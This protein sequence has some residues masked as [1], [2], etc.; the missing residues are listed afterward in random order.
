M[1][2]DIDWQRV[3]AGAALAFAAMVCGLA[4]GIDPL[5]AIYVSVAIAFLVVTLTD[6][7]MGLS[8]FIFAGFVSMYAYGRYDVAARSV[9]VLAWLMYVLTR[10]RK[11]LDFQMVHPWAAAALVLFVAWAY[12]SASWSEDVGKAVLSATEYALSGLLMLITYTAV[13]QR[14]DLG[15]ILTAFLFGAVTAIIY[16]LINPQVDSEGRLAN[17]VLGPNVLGEALVCGLAIGVALIVMYR[18]PAMRL[19]TISATLFVGLGV[20]LTTSR[21]ALLALL[22]SLVTAIVLAGRWRVVALCATLVLTG[23]AYIYFKQFAPESQRQRIEQPLSSQQRSSDGRNTIWTLAVRAFEAH[24]VT[25]VGAGNFRVVQR[26]FLLQPGVDRSATQTSEVVDDP[27]GK[28]AHNSFLS[29]ASE[30]GAVGLVLFVF[31]I[32]FGFY[33]A[34]KAASL[35][36]KLGDGR[37]QVVAISI[38]VAIVGSLG[39][40]MFQSQQQ[41]KVI[42]LLLGL[43]PATL[44]LARSEARERGL[45]S[46]PRRA[47]PT[48]RPVP[49]YNP[50]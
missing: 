31:L 29:V 48:R 36:K 25:G 37:M 34:L 30:L 24:P 14:R 44:T 38:V 27:H 20:L 16:A 1:A 22:A 32:G 21:S 5:V 8:I 41:E 33:S 28:V 35:F 40:Q 23:G 12:L 47:R 19:A 45:L 2:L 7:S 15:R 18:G 6:L 3:V 39:V 10:R 17:V 4:A 46:E 42:W 43:A 9:L 13:Q 49:V 26:Q 50:S 11:E